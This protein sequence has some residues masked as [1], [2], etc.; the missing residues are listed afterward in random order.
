MTQD[1]G[2][3][4]KVMGRWL[5]I[6]KEFRNRQTPRKPFKGEAQYS[7]D[8]LYITPFTHELTSDGL[9]RT[10]YTPL[11]RNMNPSGINVLDEYLQ[12]LSAGQADIGGFCAR[13]NAKTSD[14]D[15]LMFLLTGMSNVDFRNRWMLRCADELLRH[16][17]MTMPEIARRCG[18]GTRGNLYFIYERELNCSPSQR[19]AELRKQGDLGK[20]K[21][22]EPPTK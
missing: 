19:R 16:T 3:R 6:E 15:G 22:V 9:G 13:H 7:L 4:A 14:L 17:D 18:A 12:A 2:N 1:K 5:N 10:G 8:D 21:I 20:Y 11:E